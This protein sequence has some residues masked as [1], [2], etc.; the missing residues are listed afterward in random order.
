MKYEHNTLHF[1]QTRLK[2]FTIRHSTNHCALFQFATPTI[3]NT[4]FDLQSCCQNTN[5]YH[6]NHIKI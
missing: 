3:A 4:S 1:N 2:L 5:C 6:H